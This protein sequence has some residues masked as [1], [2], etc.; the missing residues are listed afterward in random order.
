VNVVNASEHRNCQRLQEC[1]KKLLGRG[2]LR[3][4]CNVRPRL[5][6]P[7]SLPSDHDRFMQHL[8]SL[9]DQVLTNKPF[10]SYQHLRSLDGNWKSGAR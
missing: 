8:L 1:R 3:N 6:D 2:V 9:N 7:L 10:Q 4:R 5:T